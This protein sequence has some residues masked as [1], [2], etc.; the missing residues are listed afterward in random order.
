MR[1][2]LFYQPMEKQKKP[3]RVAVW[4]LLA[5]REGFSSRCANSPP[6][7]WLPRP[8]VLVLAA[9]GARFESLIME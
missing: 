1:H 3:H 8:A 7:C 5:R 6:D 4:L 2:G 9:L